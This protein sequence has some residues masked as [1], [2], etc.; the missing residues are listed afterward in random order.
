MCCEILYA[1]CHTALHS[2]QYDLVHLVMLSFLF[3]Q[4]EAQHEG[5]TC[6]DFKAWK[7]AN[8]PDNQMHGLHDHLAENGISKHFLDLSFLFCL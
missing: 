1:V 4:W 8:D 3:F 2:S 6:A 5:V 7:I